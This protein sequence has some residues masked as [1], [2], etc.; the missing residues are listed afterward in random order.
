MR[1]GVPRAAVLM[2]ECFICEI[3]K[4]FLTFH[5]HQPENMATEPV[6]RNAEHHVTFLQT[7]QTLQ[8]SLTLLGLAPSLGPCSLRGNSLERKFGTGV[9]EH[10]KQPRRICNGSCA[11]LMTAGIRCERGL[12]NE[13]SSHSK[14]G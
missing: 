8:L 3:P 12:Q 10:N 13:V 11:L 5:I 2:F 1:F 4:N 6:P 14:F 7:F 9:N